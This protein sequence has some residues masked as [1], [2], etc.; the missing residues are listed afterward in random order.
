MGKRSAGITTYL[1][2]SLLSTFYS[3]LHCLKFL[4][5][6]GHKEKARLNQEVCESALCALHTSMCYLF[7]LHGHL[8]SFRT[9]TMQ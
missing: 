7:I 2:V 4:F 5:N 6:K 9:K 3:F 8:V 1:P